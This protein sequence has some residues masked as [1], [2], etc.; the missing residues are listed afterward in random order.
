V[1]KKGYDLKNNKSI[2][3]GKKVEY[4]TFRAYVFK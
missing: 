3:F 2:F 4:I 1:Y